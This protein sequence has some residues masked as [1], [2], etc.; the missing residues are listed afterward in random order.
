MKKNCEICNKMI[1]A[2]NMKRH[3]QSRVHGLME[4]LTV[5]KTN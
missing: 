1:T 3:K 5:P 4:K 2:Q